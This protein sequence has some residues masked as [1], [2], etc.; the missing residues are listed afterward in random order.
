MAKI[1]YQG[2]TF[3]TLEG[4][5]VLNAYL[6]QGITVP[7]SCRN[8]VCHSCK[9]ICA[10]GS[11]PVEAQKSL[12][13][14][15]REQGIF[16]PCVCVP[17]GDMEIKPFSELKSLASKDASSTRPKY[18][19][20]DLE[21]WA[22]LEEGQLLTVI[23][24]DF[25]SRVYQDPLLSPY[26]HG[27]TMQRSIEKVYSFMR[28][29]CTGENTFFGERPKNAHHWMVISEEIFS[30]REALMIDCHRRAGLSEAMSERWMAMERYYKQDIVKSEP[31][32]R[33][34][35]NTSLPLEG[36]EELIIDSGTIC[37]GCGGV[38]EA[39]ENVKYHLRLGTVYCSRCND[40]TTAEKVEQ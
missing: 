39:G 14:T 12:S 13:A 16:L 6:R 37:D 9:Q 20:P 40:Q 31:W 8:G 24:K 4:E 2:Q 27:T 34:F 36:F 3:N 1:S 30:H 35:G 15:E 11:I 5:K 26:F 7:F 10:S 29:I 33:D 18:P 19:P 17:A 38:I 32:E 25:Y 23:L 28:Q 22:A 21:L